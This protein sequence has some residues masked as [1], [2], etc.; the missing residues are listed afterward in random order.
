MPNQSI[1]QSKMTVNLKPILPAVPL[2]NTP[3]IQPNPTNHMTQYPPI[4]PAPATTSSNI[5]TTTNGSLNP[6]IMTTSTQMHSI[7]SNQLYSLSPL[8]FTPVILPLPSLAT[9]NEKLHS[10]RQIDSHPKSKT[11]G[12]KDVRRSSH[13]AIEKR[14]RSSINDKIL[15]LKKLVCSPSEPSEK[16]HKAAILKNSID[17]IKKL[18]HTNQR[19]ESEL[20]AWKQRKCIHCDGMNAQPDLR[21]LLSSTPPTS[22]GESSPE[23]SLPSSPSSGVD[24]PESQTQQKSPL[25]LF[26]IAAGL[27][28]I[29]PISLSSHSHGHFSGPA[30]HG[31]RVERSVGVENE[32]LEEQWSSYSAWTGRLVALMI[33]FALF[34]LIYFLSGRFFGPGKRPFQRRFSSCPSWDYVDDMKH[35]YQKALSNQNAAEKK[36]RLEDI[37]AEIAGINF[38]HSNLAFKFQSW[39]Q[40]FV[41]TPWAVWRYDASANSKSEQKL[42]L[43]IVAGKACNELGSLEGPKNYLY[44]LRGLPFALQLLNDKSSS[45]VVRIFIF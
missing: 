3:H 41:K 44:A 10:K 37:I 28:L 19:L 16:V 17:A 23:F 8:S 31:S 29:N 27:F 18:Q 42:H 43:M 2:H 24:S 6:N 40:F 45:Q 26:A 33:N 35:R 1:P 32:Y 25:A 11:F 39:F 30:H 7:L 38:P 20:R 22:G 5:V 15:E 36:R 13:N 4:Q 34:L 12:K 14:Y 9:E 21:E